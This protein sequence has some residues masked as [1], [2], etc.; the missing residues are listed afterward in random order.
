MAPSH[1]FCS[2]SCKDRSY[3]NSYYKS[4]Y[5]LT[6]DEVEKLLENQ[7]HLCAICYEEGFKMHQG[8]WTKLCI[9]HDH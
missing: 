3:S 4:T 5:G 2:D 7:N 6:I 9:D 1:L 8:V